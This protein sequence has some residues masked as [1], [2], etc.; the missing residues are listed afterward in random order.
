MARKQNLDD[1]YRGHFP[2]SGRRCETKL[3]KPLLTG[4]VNPAAV[5]K[6]NNE[7]QN[8]WQAMIRDQIPETRNPGAGCGSG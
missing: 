2:A 1:L 8:N 7:G 5:Y 4:R 3:Q 6:Q